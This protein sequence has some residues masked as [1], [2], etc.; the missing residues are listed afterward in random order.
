M[1][2]GPDDF[3]T[4]NEAARILRVSATTVRNWAADGRIEEHRTVGGHR[5]FRVSDVQRLA[6]IVVPQ[7]KPIIL[8]IDDD[9]SIRYVLREAFNSVGFEVV[10][11]ESGLLGLD[12]LDHRPPALVL[13]DI[14]MPGID[15]F[16]VM[17]YLTQFGV[18]IPVLAM[19]ALGPRVEERSME[20]GAS[21]FISKPFDIRELVVTAR[22]VIEQHTVAL[23]AAKR[24]EA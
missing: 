22:R 10:E 12:A 3:L 9:P 15:G 5:R 21:G 24:D 8:V 14:M 13:L 17:K 4:V 7:S 16:Q 6:R 18:K 11:A 23:A 1:A 19:S 20:L 2:H